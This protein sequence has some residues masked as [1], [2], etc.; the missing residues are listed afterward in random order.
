MEQYSIVIFK[1]CFS[2]VKNLDL[3]TSVQLVCQFDR[4]II[5]ISVFQNLCEILKLIKVESVLT[6][7][8]SI[9]KKNL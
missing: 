6:W 1:L 2:L 8:Q 5:D 7:I 4:T 9:G 3:T